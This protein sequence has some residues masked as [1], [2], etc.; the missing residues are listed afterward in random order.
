MPTEDDIEESSQD[1]FVVESSQDDIPLEDVSPMSSVMSMQKDDPKDRKNEMSG[2]IMHHD[3]HTK[4]DRIMPLVDD[5]E[6]RLDHPISGS[7]ENLQQKPDEGLAGFLFRYFS[8]LG[9]R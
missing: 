3:D 4:D 2:S 5:E 8:W 6:D 7:G 9:K 1:P